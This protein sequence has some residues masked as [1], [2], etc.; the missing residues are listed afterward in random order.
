[1]LNAAWKMIGRFADGE[2]IIV[3]GY[4]EEQCMASLIGETE[5]HGELEWY[6]GYEGNGYCAGEY[7][8]EL[9]D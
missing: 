8:G 3:S 9:F 6:G 4:S 1:M 7:I 2:E 5:F